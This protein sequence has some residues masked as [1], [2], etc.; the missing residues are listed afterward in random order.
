ML[1]PFVQS[2]NLLL[3]RTA[4]AEHPCP[5]AWVSSTQWYFRGS[6]PAKARTM[7]KN[8]MSKGT[9]MDSTFPRTKLRL[10]ALSSLTGCG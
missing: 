6:R 2:G 10:L 3:T 9:G 4:I 5:L 7:E 1:L 8:R